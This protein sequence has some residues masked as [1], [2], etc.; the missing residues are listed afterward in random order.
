MESVGQE[1]F[2]FVRYR[3]SKDYTRK[4]FG[5]FWEVDESDL[6]EIKKELLTDRIHCFITEIQVIKHK[7]QPTY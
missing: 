5:D 7:F 6:V 4:C 3:N 1:L 2:C